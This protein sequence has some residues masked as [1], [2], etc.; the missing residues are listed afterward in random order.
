M[1]CCKISHSRHLVLRSLFCFL[2]VPTYNETMGRASTGVSFKYHPNDCGGNLKQW[3][4]KSEKQMQNNRFSFFTMRIIHQFILIFK[5]DNKDLTNISNILG[6]NKQRYRTWATDG[7]TSLHLF[8]VGWRWWAHGTA[9]C[10]G[11]GTI[12][13]RLWWLAYAWPRGWHY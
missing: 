6:F 8:N 12:L 3:E 2:P 5:K 9:L 13:R 10:G 7:K 11:Q 1:L 4:K